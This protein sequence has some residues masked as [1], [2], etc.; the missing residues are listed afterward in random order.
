MTW[1]DALAAARHIIMTNVCNVF[2]SV[3]EEALSI[4]RRQ[5]QSRIKIHHSCNKASPAIDT[6]NERYRYY[7]NHF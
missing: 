1:R 6:M 5:R 7:N 3:G 2:G 4:W